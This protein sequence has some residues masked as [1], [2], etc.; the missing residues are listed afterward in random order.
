MLDAIRAFF[1]EHISPSGHDPQQDPEHRL[2]VAVAALLAEVVRT[3]NE[4]TQDE[5]AQALASIAE[6]FDLDPAQATQL[7]AL[8]E[9]EA[10]L[11]TDLYQFTSQINRVFSPSEKSKLIEHMWRVAYADS[12]L[13]RHEDHLIRKIAD[14]IHVP[15]KEFIAAKLRVRGDP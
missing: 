9:E 11:A 4:I 6:R 3:D 5:R 13:H 1:E 15:H 14:L 12:I 7:I 2:R 8:A 10:R